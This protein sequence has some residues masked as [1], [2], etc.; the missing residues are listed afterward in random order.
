MGVLL[1]WV[2]PYW[3]YHVVTWGL[4]NRWLLVQALAQAL[5]LSAVL[6]GQE[7][8]WLVSVSRQKMPRRSPADAPPASF[9][10]R[11]HAARPAPTA[12]RR[13]HVTQHD[14]LTVRRAAPVLRD[15]VLV[16]LSKIS[17]IP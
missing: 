9:R 3:A 2:V 5:A 15:I 16:H 7:A 10:R 13:Q 17:L 11:R 8:G 14:G 1:P 12:R 4:W 6:A